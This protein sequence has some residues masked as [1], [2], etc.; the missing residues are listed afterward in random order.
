MRPETNPRDCDKRQ[1]GTADAGAPALTVIGRGPPPRGRRW[2]LASAAIAAALI[3][4]AALA[5]P[6]VRLRAAA[7]AL[8]LTGRIPDLP[9]GDLLAMLRP[10][11]KELGVGRLL[12][13]HNPY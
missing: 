4:A 5:T 11:S 8:D 12:A 1:A 2:K 3:I 6:A 7:L 10:G 9:L 13:T